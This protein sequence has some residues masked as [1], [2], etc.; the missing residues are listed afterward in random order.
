MARPLGAALVLACAGVPA[1]AP[2]AAQVDST[3][4]TLT[5][6]FPPGEWLD[7]GATVALAVSPAPAGGS[8]L[9]VF[10]GPTDMTALFVAADSTLTWRPG[11]LRLPAGETE[12]V[13]HLVSADGGWREIG[14]VPLRVRTRGGWERAAFDPKLELG[15]EGQ[16][17][18]DFDPAADQPGRETFQDVTTGAGFT[19]L[20]VRNGWSLGSQLNVVGVSQREKA[21]RFSQEGTRAPHVDLSDYRV[22][23][24]KGIVRA[25]L[26]HVTWEGNRHLVGQ[27]GSRGATARIRL[28]PGADLTAAWLNGSS[29]VGW[30]NFLGLERREHRLGGATFGLEAF[31]GRPG[32]LRMEA[33]GLTGSL[34]PLA[35]FT[36][37]VVNDTE[38]SR[39]WGMRL[40]A[41]TPDGRG[42]I[43]AGYSRSRFDN[44]ADPLLS[45]GVALVAVRETSRSARYF[46]SSLDLVQAW[47]ITPTLQ[48]RLTAAYRHEQTDPLYRSIAATLQ[49]DRSS[50]VLELT[51]G[52]GEA[53]VQLSRSTSRDNLDRVPSILVT[54]GRDWALTAGA[55]IGFLL[56]AANRPAW[57]PA[58]SYR[59]QRTHQR[60]EGIPLGSDARPT[61][62]PDQV[63]VVHG[64]GLDW[65]GTRWRAAYRLDRSTQDN[66]QPERERADNANLVHGVSL[67]LT[68]WPPLTVGVELGYERAD[69]REIARV[70]RTRRTGVSLE[71]RATRATTLGAR[72]SRTDAEDD[73][74]IRESDGSDLNLQLTQRLD[75]FQVGGWTPPGQAFLRFGRVTSRALDREFLVDDSRRSWTAN[76][77]LNLTLF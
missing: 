63:S 14:R 32:L 33:T 57:L 39:G 66:R 7:A 29:I 25:S 47:A 10:V 27:F 75:V 72:W 8:R 45:Q 68:V 17:A 54:R 61:F 74:R 22:D 31:P 26:G 5:P 69:N 11:A 18:Q 60:G 12:I 43:E 1:A 70:D 40:V 65:Q 51:G 35:G 37:G 16:V 64:L 50:H 48:G 56:G 30:S 4:V 21:L 46:E 52:V 53:T 76:T 13:V 15:S 73:D 58:L 19:S 44:P 2:V 71:W 36:E 20:H 59:F 38:K 24:E 62:V 41:A 42:R 6:A 9:A 49:A 34:L 3:P 28:G 23:V 55:P 77:G 67:E